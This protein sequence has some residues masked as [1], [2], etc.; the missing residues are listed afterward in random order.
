MVLVLSCHPGALNSFAL[1]LKDGDTLGSIRSRIA[2]KLNL[3]AG[4]ENEVII[5]YEW[6]D[7]LYL[8]EDG[9]FIPSASFPK[10]RS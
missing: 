9:Q 1:K 4:D 6:V 2:K 8:L 5:K 10:P 3:A 7:V